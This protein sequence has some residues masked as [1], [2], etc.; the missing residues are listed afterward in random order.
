MANQITS[1][2]GWWRVLLAFVAKRPAAA[3]FLCFP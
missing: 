3:E 2:G 1:A